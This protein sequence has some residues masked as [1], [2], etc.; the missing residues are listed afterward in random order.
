VRIP[1][2]LPLS[3]VP[4]SAHPVPLGVTPLPRQV[5]P[6]RLHGISSF[7]QKLTS[8]RQV[9]SQA[10][11]D[12][13]VSAE[14]RHS[15]LE[16]VF[17]ASVS[18][19]Q[20]E[21]AAI[22]SYQD[23]VRE[24]TS[25]GLVKISDP[26][27]TSKQLEK[28]QGSPPDPSGSVRFALIG[29]TGALRS[30]LKRLIW[31]THRYFVNLLWM[32]EEN[33]KRPGH[34]FEFSI[35]LGDMVRD[36]TVR[37]YARLIK[38]L[39]K[40]VSWPWLT[41]LGNH[42]RN[43]PKLG[44]NEQLYQD[45]FGK[46]EH[47]F[48]RGG[49]RFIFLNTSAGNLMQDQLVWLEGALATP[50]RKLVF[51]HEPPAILSFAKILF[52]RPWIMRW[53][54]IWFRIGGFKGKDIPFTN[55]MAKYQVDRVYLGHTHGLVVVDYKGVRYV[56]GGSGGSPIYPFFHSKSKV[57]YIRVEAG[58]AGIEETVYT[59]DGSVF[60]LPPESSHPKKS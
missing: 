23:W 56:V 31:S 57:N 28:I 36:G 24:R 2:P 39:G 20:G 16:R 29:D 6:G 60:K 8:L 22:S 4:S 59:L 52:F 42:D 53:A 21:I 45:I 55:L 58:P 54:Q 11:Q 34:F 13:P 26:W 32:M 38:T 18:R 44:G 37:E 35:Q 48:D 15:G 33:R 30:C 9:A 14:E 47:Y 1:N 40:N 7:P 19:R 49:V 12:S 43:V 46:P 10:A 3:A 17:D 25:E 50:L 41:V 27:K 5:A 51:T